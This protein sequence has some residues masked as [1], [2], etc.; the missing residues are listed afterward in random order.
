MAGGRPQGKSKATLELIETCR[1]ILRRQHPCSV[2]AVC[3]RLFALGAIP[4]MRTSE[5]KR[6]SRVLV[7]AREA[8]D[9][10]WDWI[11]DETRR[12]ERVATW[13]NPT[14][15]MEAAARQ[16]RRDAWQDQPKRVEV[17]SEKGTV[18]GTLEPILQHY[19]VP[20][21]VM[22][23]FGSATAVND[24]AAEWASLEKE[25]VILYAGDHDP[26]G[27]YMSEADLPDRLWRYG[28]RDFSIE[29]V[30][31]LPE[32]CEDLPA[33]PVE[34]KA[35]DARFAWFRENNESG[36]RCVELDAMAPE[37]L[38]HLV[39]RAIV[40]RLDLEAWEHA[41]RVNQA[42]RESMTAFLAE[43]NRGL[44]SGR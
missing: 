31:L 16:Y 24:A 3:Y 43:W 32:H 33:F 12:I 9:I 2:R 44:A 39:E 17:W 30:A 36:D 22:H 7:D 21:R 23:G 5:T 27:L 10:P 25:I 40:A 41:E 20:L 18:R 6:I 34:T 38:R 29:R 11:V 37:D 19:A 35:G 13:L 28:A 4:S 1:E 42:E 15:M 26:S 8:G 14:K